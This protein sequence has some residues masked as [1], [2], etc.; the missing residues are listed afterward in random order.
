ME[1][2]CTLCEVTKA[3]HDVAVSERDF[4][5]YRLAKAL[6]TIERLQAEVRKQV[7]ASRVVFDREIVEEAQLASSDPL[8]WPEGRKP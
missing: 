6:K 3:F 5:R 2:G 8:E 4:A 1:S 7:F